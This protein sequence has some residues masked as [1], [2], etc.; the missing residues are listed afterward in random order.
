V[1][2]GPHGPIDV[3]AI[4]CDYLVCSGYKIFSPHMGFAW[5]RT[6]AINRLPTFR[7]DFIPD[8]TPDKLEAGTYVYENVAGMEA[9]VRY[10]ER[11]GERAGAAP[12]APRQ[13]VI[14]TAMDAIAAYER[15]LSAALLDAVLSVDGAVVYGVTDRGQLGERVPTVSFTVAG[16]QSSAIAAQLA[17]RG[18]GARSGHMYSPRLMQRLRLMPEGMVRVSLVHYNT[19]GEIARFKEAFGEIVA[20][21]RPSRPQFAGAPTAGRR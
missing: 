4:D 18:I 3:Q 10:L 15:T 2:F 12:G 9:V 17:V 6:E 21:V 14:R 1:H 5:C 7:E 16:V 8:V 11:L 13:A 20:D 19:L